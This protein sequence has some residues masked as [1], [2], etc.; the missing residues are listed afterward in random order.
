M[1]RITT[2]LAEFAYDIDD[3]IREDREGNGI[4]DKEERLRRDYGMEM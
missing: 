3:R 4:F 2:A 1:S